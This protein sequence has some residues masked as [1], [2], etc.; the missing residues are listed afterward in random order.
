[1]EWLLQFVPQ[2]QS[3]LVRWVVSALMVLL[4]F[5]CRFALQAHGGSYAFMLFVPLIIASAFLFDRGSGVVALI[6]STALSA[7]LLD[8]NVNADIHTSAL[9]TFFI[10][11]LPLVLI[12]EGLHR[13]LERALRAEEAQSALLMEKDLL[14]REMKHRVKNEFAMILSLIGLQSRQLQPELREALDAIAQRVRV[15]S[16]IHDR[17]QSAPADNNR[18]DLAEYL[19]DL[20][21]SL[22]DSVRELR[23]VAVNVRVEPIMVAPEQALSLGLIV[24]ELVTN[25]LKHAFDEAA[26]GHVEV[27]LAKQNGDL[28]L[29]VTDNGKGCPEEVA[30]GLGT[31]L[32]ALLVDQLGGSIGRYNQQQG[33]RVSI[34]LPAKIAHL[35]KPDAE[36]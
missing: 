20:C 2:R 34:S 19:G 8:W 10:V 7:A 29:S 21:R 32:I 6:L 25:T 26:I 9:A 16:G 33:C 24:N 17:L 35:E 30:R 22:Q 5:A 11:G 36:A 1:M 12:G 13:A 31:Q 18:V 27:T 4:A 28:E 23:P 3:M 15:I 14:L